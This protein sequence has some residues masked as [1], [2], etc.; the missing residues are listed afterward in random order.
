RRAWRFRRHRRMPARMVNVPFDAQWNRSQMARSLAT[1]ILYTV[2]VVA[3]AMS[4]VFL[5]LQLSGDPA[6]ALIPPGSDP[7]D[8]AALRAKFGLDES[9]PEQYLDYMRHAAVGDFG[10]SWRTQ[11]PA[12]AL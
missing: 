4:I 10:N 5:M 8:V 9:L 3:T 12:M 7:A 11:Q 1:R 2:L 6:D